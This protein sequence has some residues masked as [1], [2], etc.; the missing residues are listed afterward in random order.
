MTRTELINHMI[1]DLNNLSVQGVSNMA[2]VI[3]V[4]RGLNELNEKMPKEDPEQDRPAEP[5]A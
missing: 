5:E 1:S 2:I 3:R 4:V